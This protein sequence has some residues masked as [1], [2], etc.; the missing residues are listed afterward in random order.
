MTYI[1]PN[2]TTKKIVQTNENDL[3]G[4]IYVTKNIDLRDNGYIK[5]SHFPFALMTEDDDANLSNADAIFRGAGGVFVN[6]ADVFEGE[7]GFNKFE[8]WSAATDAPTPGAE[9]DGIIFNKKTVVTD[10][11]YLH[12]MNV[13]GTGGSW[14][15]LDFDLSGPCQMAVFDKL[16]SLLIGHANT[17]KMINTSWTLVRTLVIPTDYEI[18]SITTNGNIVYIGTRHDANGEAKLFLWDGES[19]AW[20]GSYGVD[21]SEISSV[22]KYGATCVLFTS[23]GQLLQFN[24]SSFSVLANFP[25]FYNKDTTDLGGSSNDHTNVSNRG[26]YVDGE[27]IYVSIKTTSDS[28]IKY[29]DYLNPSGIWLYTPTTGLNC[30]NTFSYNRITTKVIPTTSVDITDNIITTTNVPITGTPLM[31]DSVIG[32]VIGGLNEQ[33]LYYTIKLSD[34]TLKLAT[35]YSNAIAGTAIDL[36]GT[37]NNAQML[38]FF[39]TYDFGHSYMTS[40]CSVCLLND[41][42]NTRSYKTDKIIYTA[43]LSLP[44]KVVINQ[45]SPLLPNR[46]YFIT[47]KL[48]SSNTEEIYN[49]VL[50]KHRPLNVDEKII[51]KYR[52]TERIGLPFGSIEYGGSATAGTWTDTDTFTTTLDMS[53]AE[54]GDEIEIVAGKG[55]GMLFH[56]ASLSENA[57]TWTVN[58]DETFPYAVNAETMYFYVNNFKKLGEITKETSE[59]IDHKSV[60]LNKNSKFLQLK[61]E[62]RGVDVTIEELQVS[63]KKFE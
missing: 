55:A 30:L 56:I 45:T 44:D 43:N 46:G 63:N 3:S 60:S 10:G 7:G 14:T 23:K 16:K 26:I 35:S 28:Y 32:T 15:K 27:K 11:K 36:T 42:L 29:F 39:P 49:D 50:I 59:V 17:V 52:T 25:S 18:T 61:I 31:Y 12:Y 4:N 47:P 41:G 62:L 58:L 40:R 33:T 24:G 9:E 21:A 37:G 5:L 38:H 34:T 54:V 2:Q 57:G 19:S 1:I 48:N 22:K 20:N 13:G 51:I 6:G 8:N 53:L